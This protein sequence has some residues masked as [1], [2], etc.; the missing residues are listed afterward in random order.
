MTLLI[1]TPQ[2]QAHATTTTSKCPSH[3]RPSAPVQAH[4]N[5]TI[6]NALVACRGPHLFSL[7]LQVHGTYY[8]E[9][10]R[11][12][13]TKS[14][15]RPET[16]ARLIS[17]MRKE[18]YRTTAQASLCQTLSFPNHSKGLKTLQLSTQCINCEK[19]VCE[20]SRPSKRWRKVS[21]WI[22]FIVP[23]MAI[24]WIPGILVL[25][26]TAPHAEASL[27]LSCI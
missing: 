24:I 12:M 1:S 9:C 11:S 7:A 5:L 6:P 23:A 22:L 18:T 26:G 27:P 21:R 13:R 2:D 8:P 20:I 14:S 19:Y 15:T 3:S 17:R 16:P 10:V 4:H 25:A